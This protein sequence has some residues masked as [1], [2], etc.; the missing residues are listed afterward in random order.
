MSG[1]NPPSSKEKPVR[2]LLTGATG[3]IGLHILR[4]LLD[5]GHA[6][7]VVARSPEKLGP[8]AGASGFTVV[9]ADLEQ[10]DRLLCALEGQNVCIHAALIWGEP[11]TELELRDVA[12]SAKLFD[13]AGQAGVQRSIYLSSAAVHRPFRGEMGEEDPFCTSDLYGATKAAGEL[14]L[15]AA[16]AAHRMTGIV[17]RP[18]PV[19]GPPAFAGGA[20]RSDRRLSEMVAEAK[21]GRPIYVVAGEGRQWSDVR[22]VARATTLLVEEATPQPTYLC[23]DRKVESWEVIAQRVVGLLNS[24]SEVVV[25]PKKDQLPLPYFRTER[26]EA[27]LG[28]IA[29]AGDALDAHILCLGAG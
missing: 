16:C 24:A 17:L 18:G 12:V 20:L 15:R 27:L 3:Y 10:Q 21:A 6:V 13:A 11:G 23:M 28:E 2:I 26:I 9:E 25:L 8:F 4:E 19:V 7:T 22:A 29:A 14:F 1:D 5:R